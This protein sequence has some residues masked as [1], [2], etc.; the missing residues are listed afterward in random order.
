MAL[1]RETREQWGARPP[2]G[3]NYIDKRVAARGGVAVHYPGADASYRSWS[4]A[5]HQATMRAWQKMH[6]SRGSRDLEYGSVICPC[7]IWMEG[8][9]E[10]DRPLVR[11]GSNGTSAANSTHTSVQLMVGTREGITQQEKEWL[12][13]AIRWLRSQGWGPFVEPHS[14]FYATE[15]PGDAIRNALP[16]IRRMADQGTT[17]SKGDDDMTKEEHIW[18]EDILRRV[19]S[20]H[21]GNYLEIG[22]ESPVPPAPGKGGNLTWLD[23]KLKPLADRL[24]AIEAKIK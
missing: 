3:R 11:V 6:M 2:N 21:A 14:R 1:R 20:M 8:R 5:Q 19:Q 23:R 9:T 13:E 17:P 22:K 4:H 12:A 18:L 7:G 10:W 15:C 24:A 16:E